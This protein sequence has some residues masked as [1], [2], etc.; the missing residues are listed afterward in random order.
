MSVRDIPATRSSTART[1][2]RYS[3]A[4]LVVRRG[5]ARHGGDG[6]WKRCGA[7]QAERSRL[8]WRSASAA[9]AHSFGGGQYLRESTPS[10]LPNR[11]PHHEQV[12]NLNTIP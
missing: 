1:R 6:A 2:R 8:D 11:S 10:G 7:D 3:S 12:L 5:I 9:A 4:V